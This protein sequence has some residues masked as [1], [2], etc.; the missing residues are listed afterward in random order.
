MA[1]LTSLHLSEESQLHASPVNPGELSYDLHGIFIFLS[2]TFSLTFKYH[3]V[4]RKKA[5]E[6]KMKQHIFSLALH[7]LV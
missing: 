1:E 3:R 7:H 5:Q 2:L 4:E 6:S